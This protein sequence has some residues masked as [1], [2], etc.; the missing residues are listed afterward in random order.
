M[1]TVYKGRDRQR[2]E[3]VA[4]RGG[5]QADLCGRFIREAKVLAAMT[6]RNIVRYVGHGVEPNGEPWLAMEWVEGEDLYTRLAR[7]PLSIAETIAVANG[8]A[9]GLAW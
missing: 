6:H 9:Q 3:P 5:R 7:G 8:L 4:P 1:A 2:G